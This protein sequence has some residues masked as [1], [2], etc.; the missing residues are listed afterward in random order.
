MSNDTTYYFPWVRKGLKDSATEQDIL[1]DLSNPDSLKKQRPALL[2]AADYEITPPKEEHSDDFSNTPLSV[3]KEVQFVSPGDILK[4]SENA[5]LKTVPA[6]SSQGFSRQFYPYIEFWE[7]DFPWRYTPALPNGNKLRPWLALLVCE[8]NACVIRRL[9]DG[10]PYVSFNILNETQ[11][12]RIFLSPRD[13]WKTA[14]AQSISQSDP[15]FSRLIALR[16]HEKDS[17]ENADYDLKENTNYVVLLVPSFE[18]GR[19]RGLGF[20][21]DVLEN[22]PAQAPAWEESL[23]LQK[24][25]HPQQPLDFPVYYSWNFKTGGDSFDGLVKKLTKADGLRSENKIDVS[26]MGNGFDYDIL[27][28]VPDRKV[29]GMPAATKING[30]VA[31][32]P[33]PS[34]SVSDEQVLYERLKKLMDNSSIFKE[35]LADVSCAVETVSEIFRSIPLTEDKSLSERNQIFI[36]SSLKTVYERLN[37]SKF[38]TN[39]SVTP[40]NLQTIVTNVENIRKILK[41]PKLTGSLVSVKKTSVS[42]TELTAIT[43]SITNIS[44][45]LKDLKPANI[46]SVEVGDDDPWVT[47][48]VYGAKHI[49][50]T[51]IKDLKDETVYAEKDPPEWFSQINLDI[52]YRA[53]AGLGKRTVQIHQEEFVNRAWKQ[54]EA[55][56]ALNYELYKRLLS[57]N[58]NDALKGKVLGGSDQNSA[59]YMARMMRYLSSMKNAQFAGGL[60]MQ[61]ILQESNIPT[62]FASASFQHLADDLVERV[63]GLNTDTIMQNI[64]KDQT[65]S[66][67]PDF[68]HVLT[69]IGQLYKKEHPHNLAATVLGNEQMK[70]LTPPLLE[71]ISPYFNIEFNTKAAD[72]STFLRFKPKP[73]NHTVENST[74]HIFVPNYKLKRYN[75]FFKTLLKDWTL[76]G[77]FHNSYWRGTKVHPMPRV[78]SENRG[79]V[80]HIPVGRSLYDTN[81]LNR[82]ELC[83]RIYGALRDKMDEFLESGKTEHLCYGYTSNRVTYL[84]NPVQTSIE[85]NGSQPVAKRSYYA[86]QYGAPN[87]IVLS[88]SEFEKLFYRKYC[89]IRLGGADGYY[90]IPK[91]LLKNHKYTKDAIRLFVHLPDS[92]SDGDMNSADNYTEAQ[93]VYNYSEYRGTPNYTPDKSA[94]YEGVPVLV[95]PAPTTHNQLF[96]GGSGKYWYSPSQLYYPLLWK[97]FELW[98]DDTQKVEC[99]LNDRTYVYDKETFCNTLIN[100]IHPAK[101][102]SPVH[103][104]SKD[105]EENI[106]EAHNHPGDY[107]CQCKITEYLFEEPDHVELDVDEFIKLGGEIIHFDMGYDYMHYY[108]LKLV[109]DPSE[110]SEY[111]LFEPW[112]ELFKKLGDLNKQITTTQNKQASVAADINPDAV[113]QWRASADHS[114]AYE[115]MKEVARTY[116]AE[117]FKEGKEGEERRDEYIEEL[118]QSRYPILAYPIFPEPAYYYLK[119]FSEKLFVPCIDDLPENSVAMFLSNEAFTEAYLCGMNTEMGRELLWREYPTDQRGS[120]FRKFWDSETT[121]EDIHKGNFFDIKPLHTWTTG[122]LGSHHE[123]SKTGLM[124]FLIKGNLMKQYPSTQVFLHKAT[125]TYNADTQTDTLAFVDSS[126]AEE[127][128]IKKPVIQAYMREDIYIVGFKIKFDRAVGNPK[129]GDYG[130]FLAFKEDVQDLNFEYKKMSAASNAADVANILKNDPTLYG[131]HLSLFI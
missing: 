112:R 107:G 68:D 31:G 1:G 101:G 119:M 29:I 93:V 96:T 10:S 70:N 51:H 84:P 106:F 42:A 109:Y 27:D 46:D 111:N 118:L 38:K 58:T 65:F 28:V 95:D 129:W 25:K 59:N 61:Q 77:P 7:S 127:L 82:D 11:Y 34:A 125:V 19:L 35:N 108:L 86:K 73:I 6:D 47:P 26:R 90:F 79:A 44:K 113:A 52:H 55:V 131:K 50:A 94:S 2:I 91:F 81:F 32:R 78:V 89:I 120:Y 98:K 87:V 130:Y 60:S 123:E 85:V 126:V 33:F 37:N 99:K 74:N 41:F 48:P 36:H 8:E 100:R 18:T 92:Y 102:I 110:Q 20:D 9:D 104:R 88:D 114:E 64:A 67:M 21:D 124:L 72:I 23:A 54:V 12:G 75:D 24:N 63:S 71:K 57:V 5:I 30:H 121:A 128:R 115:R 97:I 69:S 117:F 15:E 4:V 16:R 53:A 76:S 13:T 122:K 66:N 116:Y 56:N 62:S 49:M 103:G 43:D 17:T 14:H 3:T 105:H 83:K 80:R 39:N 40:E 45:A 22:I